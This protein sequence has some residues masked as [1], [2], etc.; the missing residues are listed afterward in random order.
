MYWA[1]AK[2]I[3]IFT[4]LALNIFLAINLFISNSN[5]GVSAEAE[6]DAE[7]ILR[8]RNI[9]IACK[10]PK[11]G[12]TANRLNFISDGYDRGKL[13]E[14][15]LGITAKQA[16]DIGEGTIHKN[17]NR[18]LEIKTCHFVCIYKFQS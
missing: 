17:G 12:G 13:A 4:L 5:R 14:Q 15:L 11:I 9:E 3:L 8:S 16:S 2:N 10:V 18:K 7:A 1:R 6:A